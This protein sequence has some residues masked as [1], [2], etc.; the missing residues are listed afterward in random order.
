MQGVVSG[1][2]RVGVHQAMDGSANVNVP[3]MTPLPQ[4]PNDR[5]H[6]SQLAHP[7]FQGKHEQKRPKKTE[8]EKFFAKLAEAAY[9]SYTRDTDPKRVKAAGDAWTS[10]SRKV[11]DTLGPVLDSAMGF[12]SGSKRSKKKR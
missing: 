8:G 4:M 1:S 5:L 9:Q 2:G 12:R 10:F 7:H 11:D 6:L 3:K